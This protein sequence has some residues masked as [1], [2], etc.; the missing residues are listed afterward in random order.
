MA[1]AKVGNINYIATHDGYRLDANVG[2]GTIKRFCN[3]EILFARTMRSEKR[4]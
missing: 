3:A 1:T 2:V 4:Q